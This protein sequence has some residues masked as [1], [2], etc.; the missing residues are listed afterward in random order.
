MRAVGAGSA[1]LRQMQRAELLGVGALAGLL[2][3]VAA[4]VLGGLLA[5]QVFNFTW[6][7]SPWVPLAGALAGALLALGAGW[8][9]LREVLRRPVMDTLRR[10]SD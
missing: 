7:P 3:A 5:R 8:W 9:G 6:A 1:L 4:V 10:A 2:A